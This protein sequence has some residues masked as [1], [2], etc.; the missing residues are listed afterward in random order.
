MSP[1]WYTHKRYRA[2]PTTV[3]QLGVVL[4]EMLDGHAPFDTQRFLRDKL[5]ISSELSRSKQCT[6]HVSELQ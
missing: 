6:H 4:Y 1:E 2:R 5:P 3:W